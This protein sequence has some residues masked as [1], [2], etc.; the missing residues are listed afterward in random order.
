MCLIYRQISM[1]DAVSFQQSIQKSTVY[2]LIYEN[3]IF[4]Q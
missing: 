4:T 3:D 2:N 1:K